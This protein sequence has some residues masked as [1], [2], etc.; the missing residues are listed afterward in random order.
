MPSSSPPL[1]SKLWQEFRGHQEEPESPLQHAQATSPVRFLSLSSPS[2]S[3]AAGLLYSGNNA[4]ASSSQSGS[5]SSGPAEEST[6]EFC[7]RCFAA[8]PV[9][10]F[11]S[12][13]C[14]P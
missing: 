9:E 1:I 7:D 6:L 2:S 12:H 5:R 3:T 14:C 11:A 8:Y 10:M 4:G 13:C